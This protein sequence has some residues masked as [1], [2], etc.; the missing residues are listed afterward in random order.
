VTIDQAPSQV[1]PT[2]VSPITFAVLFSEPV[3]GFTNGD[4]SIG[5]SSGGVKS[6]AISGSGASYDVDVT[7][8]TTSGTVVAGIPAASVV[9]PAGN[10]SSASTSTDNTVMWDRATHL[11]FV[12][13]PTDTVYGSTIAPAVTVAVLDA[14]DQVVTE[15][16]ASVSLTLTPAGPTLGGIV[17]VPVSGGIAT[18][19]DLT[20]D[21]VGTYT[22]IAQSS[23][24][25]SGVSAPFQITP[26]PLTITADDQSK[27]FGV[28]FTF[29]GTEFSTSGLVSGDSV[30]SVTLSSAGAPAVA[31]PGGYPITAGSAIGSGLANYTIAYVDGTLTVGNTAP[32]IGDADVT[33]SAMTP[34]PGSVTVDDPDTGQT[35]TLS[36]SSGPAH[37]TVTLAQDGTF[38]YT[39]AGTYTGPD[40]FTIEGCDDHAPS[41]CATGTVTI[42]VHPVA[43]DDEVDVVSEGGTVEVD[44]Q[45]NDIGD[46]GE[47]TIVSGPDHG[48]ARV[49]SIIYTP[50]P[51]YAGTDQVVYRVCSPN[52]PALCD[53]GTLTITVT[54]AG[55]APETDTT[56]SLGGSIADVTRGVL[57]P[58]LI[59]LLA[60]AAVVGGAA[61]TKRRRSSGR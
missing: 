17:S 15:S 37:G 47:L 30:D 27:P 5:G 40:A 41:A 23:G 55:D 10:P 43:V 57:P 51:G 1:D 58:L 12:Q 34:A 13:D 6:A 44:V 9:D 8:M 49:G 53:D 3:I 33:T 26:A 31:A 11:G 7:G 38:T 50:E 48:T 52:D 36:V 2:N 18:F 28:T 24:L 59:A 16:G 56:P 61:A 46:A 14:S 22:L 35:V 19:S 42:A 45:A 54:S 60:I 39:P 32:L 25:S 4:V 20:I 29:A 21:A